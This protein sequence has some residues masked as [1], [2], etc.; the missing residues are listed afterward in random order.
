MKTTHRIDVKGISVYANHG[1]MDEE[2]RIGA[3]YNVDVSVWANL[4]QSALTDELKDTV[5]Y[6]AL[7]AIV[8]EE[9]A[10]RAKLLEV[11][12]QRITH[13]IFAEHP[14]ITRA[15]VEVSKLSP[16]INGNVNRVTVA[17]STTTL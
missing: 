5:D 10:I 12:A 14:E 13:R 11:V 9:M 16:P 3:E 7:N 2:A 1:C 6:V 8:K 4:S 15:D 17:F